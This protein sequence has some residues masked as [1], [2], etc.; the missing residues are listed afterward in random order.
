[1]WK[2]SYSLGELHD[3]WKAGGFA[4][5]L[6]V[7]REFEHWE[8]LMGLFDCVW[9]C[10]WICVHKWVSMCSDRA[11]TRL[12]RV[13]KNQLWHVHKHMHTNALCCDSTNYL[14]RILFPPKPGHIFSLFLVNASLSEGSLHIFREKK[15]NNISSTTVRELILEERAR[16]TVCAPVCGSFIKTCWP[17]IFI[18]QP[19]SLLTTLG[20]AR[21]H[22]HAFMN[23]H[24][25]KRK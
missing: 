21:Q 24:T 15:G 19:V 8:C 3:G 9:M 5:V 18:N 22:T 2:E 11:E 17:I 23:V 20:S 10:V 12:G 6:N 13:H 16:E 25:D 7:I 1:M 4:R 14:Q